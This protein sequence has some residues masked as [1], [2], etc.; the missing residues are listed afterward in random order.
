MTHGTFATR[1][2]LD[3]IEAAYQRWQHDPNSVDA[4]WRLFFEG[5]E[6]GAARAG[7]PAADSRAQAGIFGLIYAYRNLGH[8]LARLDPLSDARA[9]H[10]LL[11]LSQFGLEESDL[12]RT[13][14]TSLFVGLPRATLRELLAALRETY[15]RAIGVEFMHIQDTH[16]RR[17]LQERMEPRRNQPDYP[18]R[19]K[20]R[21]LI[22]LHFAELFEKFLHTR[23]V[24][25]KRFSL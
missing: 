22:Y 21:I 10:P 23:Y 19:R 5:F 14:D 17:W 20:M 13:F 25:Q 8:F 1:W 15:C 18:R 12:D 9:S 11:A 3:A 16:I 2:N 7:V 6:L 4:S 24:G